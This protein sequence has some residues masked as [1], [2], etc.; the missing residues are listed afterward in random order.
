MFE[1]FNVP[2]LYIAVQVRAGL[3]KVRATVHKFTEENCM[4]DA[5]NTFMYST[6]LV[7]L[8]DVCLD[9]FLLSG[10]RTALDSIKSCCIINKNCDNCGSRPRTILLLIWS[11]KKDVYLNMLSKHQKAKT[12]FMQ[13]FLFVNSWVC[14]LSNQFLCHKWPQVS[15][16]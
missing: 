7:P 8:L 4:S 9:M 10:Y 5:W 12:A 11:S 15:F 13:P 2:G 16:H 6:S 1:S 3:L 14:I